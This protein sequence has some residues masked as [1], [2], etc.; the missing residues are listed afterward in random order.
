MRQEQCGSWPRRL[1]LRVGG[2]V[3]ST[4]ERSSL[5]WLVRLPPVQRIKRSMIYA[6]AWRVIA[7][8]DLLTAAGVRVWVAGGWGVDA[9]LDRQTR[10]HCDID[11]VI[12]DDGS[13][14][15]QVAQ[16][17]AR[18]DFRFVGAYHSPGIRIPWCHVWHHDAGHTV[19]VLP[20]S[21]NEP[22][23]APVDMA[24]GGGWQPFTE[25]RIDGRPVPC[26]S[27]ELQL[28]LHSGYPLRETDTRDIALL[29][30]YLELPTQRQHG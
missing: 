29:R 28:L 18:E 6:P 5:A 16:L 19:E 23:F 15:Q 25:G 7:L 2:T 9:L 14:C 26:L 27:A 30:A 4:I 12:G 21:L 24:G 11:L 3:Y 17:L 20:V 8:L 1:T 10:R 13:A 22:P